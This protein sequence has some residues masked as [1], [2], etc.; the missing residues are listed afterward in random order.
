MRDRETQG[1]SD[2]RIIAV[3]QFDDV[4]EDGFLVA[5]GR[6]RPFQ[7]PLCALLD[8][9]LLAAQHRIIRPFLI[10]FLWVALLLRSQ[11]PM[12]SSMPRFDS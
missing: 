1:R 6:C 7:A 12:P 5:P 4:L 10:G 11:L 2:R 8:G 9:A 3:R